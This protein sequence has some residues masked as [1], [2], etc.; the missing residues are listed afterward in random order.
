MEHF[1]EEHF[2]EHFLRGSNRKVCETSRSPQERHLRA[3]VGRL[4]AWS[5]DRL[6]E[7]AADQ[8][9]SADDSQRDPSHGLE[10]PVGQNGAAFQSPRLR[11]RQVVDRDHAVQKR[12][13]QSTDGGVQ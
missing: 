7:A 10:I 6:N 3:D 13:T 11:A 2:V 12:D 9:L 8:S 4:F 1:V 5:S